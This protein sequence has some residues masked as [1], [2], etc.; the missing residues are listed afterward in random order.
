M[1]H[2]LVIGPPKTGTTGFMECARSKLFDPTAVRVIQAPRDSL[3]MGRPVISLNEFDSFRGSFLG[4]RRHDILRDT[5]G[6]LGSHVVYASKEPL[7][8]ARPR[9]IGTA[10]LQVHDPT[11]VRLITSV[12]DP[13]DRTVSCISMFNSLWP[14]AKTPY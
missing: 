10:Y 11:H 1:P 7:W 8:Y 13:V 12:R 3:Y 14:E 5:T 2:A 6:K 9:D 4:L